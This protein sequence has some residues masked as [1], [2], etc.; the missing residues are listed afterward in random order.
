MGFEA[1]VSYKDNSPAGCYENGSGIIEM[2]TSI[3]IAVVFPAFAD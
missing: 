3:A 2:K 1:G